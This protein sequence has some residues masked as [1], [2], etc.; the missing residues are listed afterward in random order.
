[1]CDMKQIKQCVFIL[2]VAWSVAAG[3]QTPERPASP[4]PDNVSQPE[5]V[6]QYVLGPEDQ[7][8]IWALG[9][10]EIS[11]KPVRIDPSGEID[12]P[13][14]GRVHAAGLTV[15]QFKSGLAK[16]LAKEVREPRVSVDIVEFGSQPISVMGAVN[17]PGVLQ[18]SGRKTLAEVLSLAGGLRTD[19]GPYVKITRQVKYGEIP[20]HN[21]KTDESG[22]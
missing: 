8:K 18:V 21:A 2:M 6:S 15:E 12:L 22:K 13:L 5:T 3:Q 4:P 9:V 10:E 7:I 16:R 20:I 14:V 19:A 17:H 11:D 1:M